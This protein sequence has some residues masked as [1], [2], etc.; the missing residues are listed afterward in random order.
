MSW[1][2]EAW[3]EV[4]EQGHRRRFARLIRMRRAAGYRNLVSTI[5]KQ[6]R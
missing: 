3:Q 5:N 1:E 4:P 2:I 6:I